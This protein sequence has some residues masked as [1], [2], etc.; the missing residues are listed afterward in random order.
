[1]AADSLTGNL[2]VSY[3]KF[4]S[5]F[6]SEI[7]FQRSITDG[8]SWQAAAKRS[9]TADDGLVQGSRVVVGPASALY[10]PNAHTGVVNVA[11]DASLSF[12]TIAAGVPFGK[13]NA[14]VNTPRSEP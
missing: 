2:Y 14:S 5:T 11:M 7:F 10:G 8:A 1:M 13:K 6:G 12:W 4:T 9:A 3:T